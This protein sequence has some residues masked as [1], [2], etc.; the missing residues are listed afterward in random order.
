MGIS[1]S[2]TLGV[3][4]RLHRSCGMTL[5]E[6]ESLLSQMIAAGYRSPVSSLGELLR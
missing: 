2:G 6:A 4:A 3:L 1:V 5:D